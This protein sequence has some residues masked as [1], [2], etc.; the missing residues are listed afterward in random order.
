MTLNIFDQKVRF[1]IS[2][3]LGWPFLRKIEKRE[4]V[5]ISSYIYT[6]NLSPTFLWI[7]KFDVKLISASKLVFFAKKGL[8][9]VGEIK[10]RT[11]RSKSF[12]VIYLL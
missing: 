10:K 11:F 5:Y 12:T 8:P 3:T 6:Q 1:L 9:S 4:L 2:P 7:L